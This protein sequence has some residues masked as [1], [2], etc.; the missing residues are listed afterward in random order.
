MDQKRKLI[1][2]W[3]ECEY[4]VT[5]LSVYYQV[6]RKTI[7]KW[8]GRYKQ[9]GLE[10][11]FEVS[12]GPRTHPNATPGDVAT[13]L[14]QTKVQHANWGPRKVLFWLKQRYPDISW[15]VASTVQSILRKEGMVKPRHYR[16]HT[17]PYTQPFGE[18][19]RPNDTWS[20]DYKGQFRT[21]DGKLCYPLTI[22]DNYSRYLLACRGLNHPNYDSSRRWLERTF[23][24]YGL[25]RTI[26]SDNGQP[27]ASTGLGG[28]SRLSAW[29]IKLWVVP[30][31][32]APSHPEQNGRHER[33]HRTLKE[34]VCKPPRSCLAAQQRAFDSFRAEY[35]EERPH[36]TLGMKTPASFYEPSRRQFPTKI[37]TVEYDSWLEVRGILP[38]GCIK[39]KGEEIYISQALAGERVGL[40]QTES[41]WE[42]M[43]SFYPLGILSEKNKK[44]LPMSPV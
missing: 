18:C 42:V 14:L 33:M 37:P 13:R 23:Q 31:R 9:V 39:W 32:I 10:G 36:E 2:D 41:A 27:F 38:N 6:S 24:E 28:I 11:L 17:P 35:N 44:V 5:E 21:G 22:S 30:E 8:I 3:L 12:R 40:K 43:F 19:L 1:E 26:K 25:P 4:T 7:Y 15:P 16:H 34:A 29:L 20:I